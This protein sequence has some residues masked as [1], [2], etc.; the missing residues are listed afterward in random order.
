MTGGQCFFF[1]GLILR[2][3]VGHDLVNTYAGLDK[4][5]NGPA[6]D[7]QPGDV[8]FKNNTTGGPRHVAIV[9]KRYWD[10]LDVVDSNFVG[11]GNSSLAVGYYGGTAN[12]EIIG[13]HMYKFTQLNSQGW[14]RYSGRGRW[15]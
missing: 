1:A 4:G 9:V 15:Y 11:Y 14:K 2:R 8:I 7:A 10:G 3:A 13:R 12:S 6:R 5:S